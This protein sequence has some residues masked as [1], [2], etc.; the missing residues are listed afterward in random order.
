MA[1][2][3]ENAPPSPAS[4]TS[5]N[6]IAEQIIEFELDIEGTEQLVSEV[7]SFSD[8]D[9]ID[10]DISNLQDQIQSQIENIDQQLSDLW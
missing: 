7:P 8:E 2:N 9:T 3:L 4:T 6:N 10:Y 1:E 5:V